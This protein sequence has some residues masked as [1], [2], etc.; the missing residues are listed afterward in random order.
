MGFKKQQDRVILC[1]LLILV[2][3]ILKRD[4]KQA[5]KIG[6][7]KNKNKNRPPN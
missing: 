3:G 4:L 6:E 1:L 5:E 2:F 7:V